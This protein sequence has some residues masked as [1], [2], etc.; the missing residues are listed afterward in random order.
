MTATQSLYLRLRRG[1][2]EPGD[3]EDLKIRKT[4]LVFA[5]GLMTAAP[6]FWLAL[7]WFMGLQLSAT[8]PLAYQL[9]S[10]G[11]LIVYLVTRS[12]AFFQYTQ[13]ALFLFFP[14][15]VQLL[16]G[17][18]ISASGAVLWGFIAPVVA[19]AVLGARASVPWFVAHI[20]MVFFCGVIDFQLAGAIQTAPLVPL[21]TSV[22]FFT[23]NFIGISAISYFVLRYASLQKE[24]YATELEKT[25]ALV[26]FEQERSEK[27]LLNILPS[28]I[29]ERLK[30][31]DQT[32]ADGFADVT[33]MFADCHCG[34][35]G[36]EPDLRDAEPGLLR[37]RRARRSP[38]S[39]KDQDHRRRLHGR[40]RPQ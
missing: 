39:G 28:P 37:I 40:G 19:V 20:A 17:N 8:F 5:M 13:L 26:Q 23:M 35:N 15:I 30:R 1:G 6:M 29:A 38:R 7:Y 34:G 24:T 27:L 14:F 36:A 2:I 33:V 31:Q 18:F 16:I 10:V 12:F 4:I 32:I 22:L 9:I 3:S 25:N 11:T 21:R